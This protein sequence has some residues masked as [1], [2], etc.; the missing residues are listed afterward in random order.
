MSDLIDQWISL[1]E[2]DGGKVFW[3]AFHKVVMKPLVE[4]FQEDREGLVWNLRE[5]LGGRVV[6]GGDVAIEVIA[7]PEIFVRII[8]WEGEEDLPDEGTMMFDRELN[9]VYS[10]EDVSALL[11]Y[12]VREAKNLDYL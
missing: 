7:F 8:F 3:P 12:I 2:T 10:M 5:R 9:G 4:S 1:K 11:L 6:E